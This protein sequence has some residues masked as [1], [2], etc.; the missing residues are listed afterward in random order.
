MFSDSTRPHHSMNKSGIS[1]VLATYN[2]E[3]FL[4]KQIDSIIYQTLA[5]EEILVGDDRSDD[6]TA[7]ILQEYQTALK[8]HV[9]ATRLGAVI[10][11]KT[12]ASK[13]NQA[14]YIAFADQ[15]DIWL[16]GKLAL[17]LDHLQ[18]FQKPDLP[19]M[20]YSDP[21]IIN[22][23]DELI[24][25]S[26]W[27]LLGID[28]YPHTLDTILFGNPVSGCTMLVNPALAKYI[29]TIPDDFSIN[30]DAW[31]TLCAY[32]FGRAVVLPEQVI[33]YRQHGN[34]LTFS[35]AHQPAGRLKKRISEL[36][37]SISGRD[38]LFV[39]QFK[40]VRRFYETFKEGLPRE[41]KKIIET[42]LGLENAGY[43]RK[44]LAFRAACKRASKIRS[45]KG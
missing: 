44:K 24:S 32:T 41:K 4:R 45:N 14:N 5:P 30:H 6:D 20:V 29:D 26:L 42:F 15:D 21:K 13:V 8:V 38:D 23:Q 17:S 9:N 39:Q 33:L 10:N 34:N 7:K 3:R 18:K 43:M 36:V 28:Q 31:L 27:A 12:I 1:V 19:A 25:P 11:F 22:D 35:T 40:L 16:P 2:G 37:N